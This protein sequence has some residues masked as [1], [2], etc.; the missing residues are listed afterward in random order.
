MNR[1]IA[2]VRPLGLTFAS[3]FLS[4]AVLALGTTAGCGSKNLD[5]GG[6]TGGASDTGGSPPG[7]TGGTG[8][9]IVATGGAGGA[10]CPPPLSR[11]GCAATYDEQITISSP[12]CSGAGYTTYGRCG[13]GWSW[14]CSSFSGL[15]CVYDADKKLVAARHCDDVPDQA[16]AGCYPFPNTEC[17]LSSGYVTD[18]G[19]RCADPEPVDAGSGETGGDGG[20]P[21]CPPPL[22]SFGCAA[23]YVEQT[24]ST[25]CLS[26]GHITYGRC[27]SGWAWLCSSLYSQACVYDLDQ[28]LIA[29]Q[30]C[31]DAHGT[32]AGCPENTGAGSTCAQSS[33]FAADTGAACDISNLSGGGV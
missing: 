3:W 17:V 14:R 29:A 4:F 33:A 28:N 31:D 24:K 26:G 19:P 15:D 6:G 7:A 23:T 21:V 12:L 2:P 11:F 8:G 20:P 5:A 9:G 25:T 30:W 10:I 18:G 1:E 13:S 16:F 27:N 32:Y 22:S